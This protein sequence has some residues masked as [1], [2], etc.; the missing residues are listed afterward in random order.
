MT[1]GIPL[2]QA[3]KDYIDAHLNEWP[4]ILARHLAMYYD[5]YNKGYRHPDTI[6]DYIKGNDR[7][8]QEP[9]EVDSKKK[10]K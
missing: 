1:S 5:R 4:S 9:E 2:A 8:S 7:K 6:K 3:E 10:R